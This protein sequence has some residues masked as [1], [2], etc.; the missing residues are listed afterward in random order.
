MFL[1]E[2]VLGNEH[3]ILADDWTLTKPPSGY[4][5]I[6][7]KGWTEPGEFALFTKPGAHPIDKI[8]VEFQISS[9]TL[10]FILLCI[11]VYLQLT[12]AHTKTSVWFWHV[13]NF[14]VIRQVFLISMVKC[15]TAVTP[16]LTYW[17][18]CSLALSCR[19]VMTIFVKFVLPLNYHQ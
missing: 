3:H 1:N 11:L 14:V 6:I 8:F 16:L 5:C 18:Y 12:F 9:K 13:Q 17:S 10:L 19:Y 15:N 4:D 2:V 7:A